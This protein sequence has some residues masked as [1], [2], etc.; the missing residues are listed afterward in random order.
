MT[1]KEL[2]TSI[3]TRGLYHKRDGAPVEINQIHAR[4]NNYSHLFEKD[5]RRVR[6]HEQDVKD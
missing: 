5:A 1:T 6:V 2:V 3:N 4:V